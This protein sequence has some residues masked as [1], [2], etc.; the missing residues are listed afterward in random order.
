MYKVLL[1]KVKEPL[2]IRGKELIK[3]EY[4]YEDR[5]GKYF[6]YTIGEEKEYDR[7]L[8]LKNSIVELYPDAQVIALRNGEPVNLKDSYNFV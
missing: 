5:D 1:K 4:V 3:G 2:D 6:V 8:V 7:I